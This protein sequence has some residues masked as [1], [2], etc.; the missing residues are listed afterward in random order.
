MEEIKE[1]ISKLKQNNKFFNFILNGKNIAIIVL[2]FLLFCA[3]CAYT[4]P[5]DVTQ[6]ENQITELNT[7]LDDSNKK[8]E[9]NKKQITNLK[10]AN[11]ILQEEK[12]KL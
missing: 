7:K 11:K 8:I 3:F 9:D 5:V 1:K 4:N 6:Y 2:S 12:S 10:D